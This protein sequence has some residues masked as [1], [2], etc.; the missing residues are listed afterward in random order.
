MLSD[1][2]YK[3]D[4][5]SFGTVMNG[6]ASLEREDREVRT[7]EIF[8]L[9]E[10]EPRCRHLGLKKTTYCYNLLFKSMYSST[11]PNDGARAESL[12]NEMLKSGDPDSAPDAMTYKYV[13]TICFQVGD[14]DRADAIW[15]RAEMSDTPPNSRTYSAV[16]NYWS[17]V[18]TVEAVQRMEEIFSQLKVR[19]IVDPELRAKTSYLS[20]PDESLRD[21][22][23]PESCRGGSNV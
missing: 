17:Q 21:H 1:P 20:H 3:S 12:L 15:R 11:N 16:F 13:M 4:M 22:T 6:W 9:L 8:D 23:A 5:I 2:L 18:G 7:R 19:A 14:Y 10:T